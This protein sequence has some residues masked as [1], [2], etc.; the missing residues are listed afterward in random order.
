MRGN[1]RTIWHIRQNGGFVF[2]TIAAYYFLFLML[3]SI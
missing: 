2:G 3:N 1:V